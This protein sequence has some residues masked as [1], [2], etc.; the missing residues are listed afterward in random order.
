VRRHGYQAD[1]LPK[2]GSA[3][4]RYY[5]Q[6]GI[7]AIIFGIG[8]GGLHSDEEYADLAS[9]E[10]YYHALTEFLAR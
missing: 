9:I 6:R 1:F 8:G 2:H 4:G 10:P 7:D 5:Y 3:D